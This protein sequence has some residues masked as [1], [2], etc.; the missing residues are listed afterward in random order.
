MEVAISTLHNNNNTLLGY[1]SDQ[2]LARSKDAQSSKFTLTSATGTEAM[3]S[4]N[5]VIPRRRRAYLNVRPPMISISLYT[6]LC[7]K[8]FKN[9]QQPKPYSPTTSGSNQ[10]TAT[11]TTVTATVVATVAIGTPHT[12][13]Q[14]K[15][16]EGT[17]LLFSKPKK[18]GVSLSQQTSSIECQ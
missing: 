5:L 14:S 8:D 7:T 9:H 18:K 12:L 11:P 13:T 6:H 3:C 15:G 17:K 16:E 10:P 1:V 4:R 2:V